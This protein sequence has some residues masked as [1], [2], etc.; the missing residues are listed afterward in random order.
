MFVIDDDGDDA[1]DNSSAVRK[2][3]NVVFRD[4]DLF[5]FE[6]LR[7]YFEMYRFWPHSQ[8]EQERRRIRWEYCAALAHSSINQKNYYN[9]TKERIQLSIN[10]FFSRV[11]WQCECEVVSGRQIEEWNSKI[12]VLR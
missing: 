4:S 9:Y 1:E 10:E 6:K 11:D 8:Q 7:K 2:N 5:K 3:E 12:Q